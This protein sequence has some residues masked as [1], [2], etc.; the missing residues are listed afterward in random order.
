MLLLKNNAAARKS[1]TVQGAIHQVGFAESNP[2]SSSDIIVQT[3]CNMLSPVKKLLPRKSFGY[4]DVAIV[5]P[6][7]QLERLDFAF[8]PPGY[9]V[10]VIARRKCP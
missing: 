6:H 10:L 1:H 2:A 8:F 9:I 3:D 7:P 5:T 4:D